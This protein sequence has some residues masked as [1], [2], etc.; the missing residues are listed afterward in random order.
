MAY[1]NPG[2]EYLYDDSPSPADS[3]KAP[4]APKKD[5]GEKTALLDKSILGGKKFEVGEEVV[6]K[7]VAEHDGEIEVMYSESPPAD[8]KS[9]P[10]ESNEGEMKSMGEPSM[11]D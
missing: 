3:G 6:L 1:D 5:M 8:E 9:K 7:I 11:Y 4:D 10:E 2:K